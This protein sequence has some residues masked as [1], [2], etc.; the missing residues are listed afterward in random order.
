MFDGQMVSSGPLVSSCS[1]L[2]LE[3]GS[4]SVPNE[5]TLQDN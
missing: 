1:V 4:V 3:R 5:E 2:V